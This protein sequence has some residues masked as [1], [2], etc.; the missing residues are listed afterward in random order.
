MEKKKLLCIVLLSMTLLMLGMQITIGSSTIITQIT[1]NENTFSSIKNLDFITGQNEITTNQIGFEITESIEPVWFYVNLIVIVLT[2]LAI[3]LPS[4]LIK[5]KNKDEDVDTEEIKTNI[6]TNLSDNRIIARIGM[7][8]FFIQNITILVLY[9]LFYVL[10]PTYDNLQTPVNVLRAYFIA[11]DLDFLAAILIAVGLVVLSLRVNK[12]K[13]FAY[14][15]AG[16]WIA[17]IGLA[18]YP[19]IELT[20]GLTGDVSTSFGL[21]EFV[22]GLADYFT[23]F[24]GVD[25]LLQTF[26]FCF[27]AISLIFTTKF[28]FDNNILKG[29]GMI[30]AFGITNYVVGGLMSILILIPLTFGETMTGTAL[31]SLAIFYIIV[32]TI[33]LVAVPILGLIAGIIGFNRMKPEAATVT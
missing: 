3:I 8:L 32:L 1:E 30:N 10:I 9:I 12:S 18:I 26:G 2:P 13:I 17:F 27:L 6:D 7:L 19:R 5:N 31:G 20:T 23:T 24:Y 15:G 14:L 16:S 25:V 21:M 11:W 4:I 22:E 33:K 28:L 29:K